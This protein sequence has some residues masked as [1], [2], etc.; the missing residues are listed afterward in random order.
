MLTLLIAWNQLAV[1]AAL[2]PFALTGAACN[3]ARYL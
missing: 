2:L 1:S 3:R